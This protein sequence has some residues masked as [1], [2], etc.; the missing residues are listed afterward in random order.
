MAEYDFYIEHKPGF[1]HVIPDTLSR[2]PTDAFSVDIP[3]CP[4]ADVTSFIATAIGFDIPHHTPDSVSALFSSSLQCLYLA[5]NHID[6]VKPTVSSINFFTC[7]YAYPSSH[8][9][10]VRAHSDSVPPTVTKEDIPFPASTALDDLELLQPLNR[11]R[12]DFAKAQ[13]ADPQLSEL[14]SYIL[15]GEQQ[16]SLCHLPSKVKN[17]VLNVSKRCKLENGLLY[18]HD[19][20]MEDPSHFRIFAPSDTDLQRHLLKVYHNSPIG[21]HKGRDSTHACLSR[22]FYRRNMAKHVRNWIRRCVDCNHFKSLGQS[23]GPMQVRIYEHPFHTLRIDFVGELPCS[24]DGNKWILTAVF[25][26]SNYLVAIPVRDKT[27]TTAARALFDN[28]FLMFGFPSKLMSDHSGEWLNA[29]LDRVLKLLSI[30]HIL[31]TSYRPR[32]NGAT[33]RTHRYL[34]SALGIYCEK[35]QHLWEDYLQPAVYSHNVTPIP[36]THDLSPFF[37]NFGRHAPSPEVIT[38]EL[39]SQQI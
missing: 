19:E 33:E 3:E 38:L 35:Y 16:S 36:G 31:T 32:L 22:D 14:I 6:T 2:Y 28:I 10:E 29:V 26:F 30:E 17:W 9:Q 7:K 18:Y 5:S 11:N 39:P 24:P 15:S 1:K 23:H 13:R 8:M 21:M 4:P 20:Y 25:P 27:A 12:V 37:L 34:N